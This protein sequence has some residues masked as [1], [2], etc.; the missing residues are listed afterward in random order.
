MSL[1]IEFINLK[2]L[3]ARGWKDFKLEDRLVAVLI[4]ELEDGGS[5]AKNAWGWK[6]T[7]NKEIFS[8]PEF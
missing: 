8:V 3:A 7:L 1:E 5:M 2:W 6:Y 4:G